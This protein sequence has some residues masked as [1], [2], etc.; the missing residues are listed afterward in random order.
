MINTPII[1]P[2][3]TRTN[4]GTSFA[5][6]P[7]PPSRLSGAAVLVVESILPDDVLSIEVVPAAALSIVEGMA[8]S[9]MDVGAPP[10]DVRCSKQRQALE[11]DN[12]ENGAI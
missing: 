4:A 7:L 2:S 9:K 8:D 10:L 3:G 12:G 5:V 1:M 6:P 11:I